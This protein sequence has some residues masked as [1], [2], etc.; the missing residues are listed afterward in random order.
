MRAGGRGGLVNGIGEGG[1][2]GVRGGGIDREV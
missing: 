2:R 1:G